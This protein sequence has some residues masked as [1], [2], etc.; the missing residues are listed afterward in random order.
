[1]SLSVIRYESL[2]S[3]NDEAIRLAR[4]G[5]PAGTAVVAGRQTAGRG[6]HGRVWESPEGNLYLS[7]ITQPSLPTS[8]SGR[9]AVAA[10]QVVA[11]ALAKLTGLPVRTK[12]P[13]DLY[14][15]RRKVGGILVETSGGMGDPPWA[16]VGVG[17]NV[18]SAPEVTP[19]G[20]A[21]TSLLDSGW[22]GDL[23]SV[24][25]RIALAVLEGVG[26]CETSQ[27]WQDVTRRW[28]ELDDAFG[29]VTVVEAEAAW[30]ATGA[31]LGDD[32]ALLVL[33]D[34]K[35]RRVT[36]DVTVRPR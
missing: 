24:V 34:G 36:S 21:A 23:A 22:H 32:G 18:V 6:R 12:W 35:T 10:G 31:G 14:L 26:C 9:V 27:G 33:V 29:P 7:V 13:N 19:P 16:V 30:Q 11:V 3:T 2:P 5:A 25:E 17:V 15:Q 1:M 20:H 28:H 8:L 4:E